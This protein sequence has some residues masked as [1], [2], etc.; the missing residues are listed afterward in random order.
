MLLKVYQCHAIG[1][2]MPVHPSHGYN[3]PNLHLE[4]ETE[5]SQMYKEKERI[6]ER[7]KNG[8]AGLRG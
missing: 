2:G 3:R 7:K 4:I 1:G 5:S 8:W 6:D